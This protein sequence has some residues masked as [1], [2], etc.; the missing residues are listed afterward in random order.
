[1]CKAIRKDVGNL[2][3]LLN[4]LTESK[5]NRIESKNN[6]MAWVARDSESCQVL[7]HLPQAKVNDANLSGHR[8]LKNVL[9]FLGF[10]CECKLFCN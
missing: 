1:M 5:N 6:R 4:A 3:H 2:Q 8:V 9:E 10:L 7:T